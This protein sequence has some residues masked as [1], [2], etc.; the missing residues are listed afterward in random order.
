MS[1]ET[2]ISGSEDKLLARLHFAGRETAS[3]VTKRELA[4]FAPQQAS[5]FA[6]SSVRLLRWKM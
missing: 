4:T 5:N 1:L 3:Y 6:P 2:H